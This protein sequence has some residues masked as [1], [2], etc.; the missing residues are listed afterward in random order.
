MWFTIENGETSNPVFLEGETAQNLVPARQAP[1]VAIKTSKLRAFDLGGAGWID[2]Y[3]INTQQRL[4]RTKTHKEGTY[5][6]LSS[7]GRSLAV[8]LGAQRKIELYKIPVPG[9]KKK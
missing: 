5:Y 2:V 8:F 7:D 9:S 3:N 1:V 4:L 6:A